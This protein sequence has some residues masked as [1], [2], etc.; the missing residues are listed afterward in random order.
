MKYDGYNMI[1]PNKLTKSTKNTLIHKNHTKRKKC[2]EKFC[3][4]LNSVLW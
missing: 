2:N 1:E 4:S 3:K